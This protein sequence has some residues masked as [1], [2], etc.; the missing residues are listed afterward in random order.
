MV[1][2]SDPIDV[3]VISRWFHPTLAGGGERFR[4]YAPELRKR[5]IHLR[6]VTIQYAGA[7]AFETM[8][9]ISV[10]RIPVNADRHDLYAALIRG[11][12]TWFRATEQWPDVLHFLSHSVQGTLYVW[13][14]RFR[15]IPCIFSVTMTPLGNQTTGN[16]LKSWVGHRLIYRP[17]NCVLVNST[18]MI[19]RLAK[20]GVS[21]KRIEV[22]PNGVDVQ[23]F[24]PVASPNERDDIRR[25]LGLELDDKVILFVGFISQRK[26]VDLL[27]AAW[28][29]IVR[30]H[31]RA[32]LLLVGPRLEGSNQSLASISGARAFLNKIDR[33]VRCSPAPERVVFTGEV[34]NVEEYLLAADVFVFPSRREGMP[35]AVLEAMAT[36]LPCVLTPY[37]G[38]SAEL[39]K[40]G[41]EFLLVPRESDAVAAAVLE[42]LENKE[43]RGTLGQA[44]RNWV[45]KHLNVEKSL[46]QYAQLYRRLVQTNRYRKS[47]K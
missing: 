44:A 32:R 39:G 46:D 47:K 19:Q 7:S 24:R 22:I 14:A 21:A 37:E 29:E 35:N 5:G 28:P 11:A 40:P 30:R 43:M 15:G 2:E 23:R 42:M 18:V 6:V 36:G 34:S 17:F 20:Y 26:G 3:C 25:R 4:R 10:H 12:T 13:Y 9:G 16:R 8:D 45:E 38:L 27:V 33:V 31:P 41:R 1:T